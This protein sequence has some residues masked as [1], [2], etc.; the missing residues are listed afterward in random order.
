MLENLKSIW[1]IIKGRVI[2]DLNLIGVAV[3]LWIVAH[4][5]ASVLPLVA[6]FPAALQPILGFVLPLV[7]GVVVQYAIIQ[8]R[9][10]S[11]PDFTEATHIA[12]VTEHDIVELL[13]APNVQAAIKLAIKDADEIGKPLVIGAITAEAPILAPVAEA[14]I[15]KV[16]QAAGLAT[17]DAKPA[18]EA[19][20]PPIVTSPTVVEPA[21]ASDA[22]A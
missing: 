15:E 6:L 16:E 20:V 9:H 4:Q 7:F 11:L 3:L 19:H 8:T 22:A 10:L 21:A 2:T 1:D 12:T 14:V 13:K 17:G 18:G 5:G